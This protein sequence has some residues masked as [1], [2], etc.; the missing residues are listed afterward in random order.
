[1][2]FL[3]SY[4]APG[5]KGKADATAPVPAAGP[6]E[7]HVTPPMSMTSRSHLDS[8][9]SSIYPHGDFRNAD[10]GSV[11]DIK[12]DVMV[13]WLHQ[14]QLE[15]LWANNLPGEGVVLKKSKDNYTCCPKEL[16]AESGGFYDQVMAMNIRVRMSY[17]SIVEQG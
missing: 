12:N 3:K 14:Q 15:R 13:S 11:L 6:V 4:V 10:R 17:L 2:N 9:P 1:M 5:K 8:R 7:M 16:S